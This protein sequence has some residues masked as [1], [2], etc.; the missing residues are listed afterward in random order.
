M[1]LMK[2]YIINYSTESKTQDICLNYSPIEQINYLPNG[3]KAILNFVVGYTKIT[4]T[5]EP[6]DPDEL[7]FIGTRITKATEPSDPDDIIL[8]STIQ[9][10]S[11][12]PSDP[13]E[14]LLCGTRQT[15]SIEPIDP[16][17]IIY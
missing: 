17:D 2:P 11:I 3:R 13:D 9:T 6:I 7:D 16:D 14:L 4:E 15:F 8:F 5:V 10:R 12:E 1:K